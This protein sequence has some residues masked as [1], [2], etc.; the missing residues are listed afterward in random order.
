L[1]T[2]CPV[3]DEERK[4]LL[5]SSFI[6]KVTR[7][8]PCVKEVFVTNY[9]ND[10]SRQVQISYVATPDVTLSYVTQQLQNWNRYGFEGNLDFW[11]DVYT[12]YVTSPAWKQKSSR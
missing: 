1:Y 12:F 8:F 2:S 4:T 6:K 3:A 9:V 5:S 11:C 7:M 10:L